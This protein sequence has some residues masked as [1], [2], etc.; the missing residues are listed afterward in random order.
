MHAATGDEAVHQ[1]YGGQTKKHV[2]DETN[3]RDS[4]QF[5]QANLHPPP[6]SKILSEGTN[7][8]IWFI[9]ITK[10]LAYA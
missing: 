2:N 7:M 5:V 4:S 3:K 1:H 8:R 9:T 10:N 6:R